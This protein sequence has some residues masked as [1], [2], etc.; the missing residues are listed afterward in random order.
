MTTDRN[1]PA[2]YTQVMTE[3]R[4]ETATPADAEE[5][6]ALQKTA[7]QEEAER[8]GD[9]SIPPMLQTLEGMRSDLASHLYLKAM[10]DDR[11]VGAVRGRCDEGTCCVGRLIVHPDLQGQGLGQRLLHEVETRFP[12]ARRYELFTGHAS[13]RDLHIYKKNGYREFKREPQHEG[14]TLVYLEKMKGAES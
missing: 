10:L 6:L 9:F 4:V 12:E 3:V 5:L 13:A 1:A 8:Y 14:L 7:Y 11:I 2:A